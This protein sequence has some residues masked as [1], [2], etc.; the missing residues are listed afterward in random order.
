[1]ANKQMSSYT[2]SDISISN[3]KP[4]ITMNFADADEVDLESLESLELTAD[5]NFIMFA[6]NVL[7]KAFNNGNNFENPEELIKV[8]VK[9]LNYIYNVLDKYL[10]NDVEIEIFKIAKY[11]IFQTNMTYKQL[12]TISLSMLV[13]YLDKLK[14]SVFKIMLYIYDNRYSDDFYNVSR[15][16]LGTDITVKFD[17]YKRS[18]KSVDDPKIKHKNM[19]HL[20]EN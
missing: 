18:H 14:Q 10:T 17:I 2:V 20:F 3:K 11:L 1:M 15:E 6:T 7:I 4:R 12:A 16:I 19:P 5:D 8:V 9:A 13:P